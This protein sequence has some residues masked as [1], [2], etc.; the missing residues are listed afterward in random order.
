MASTH[1]KA[2]LLCDIFCVCTT[3]T[4]VHIR[5]LHFASV[6]P[7]LPAARCLAAQLAGHV[8]GLNRRVTVSARESLL[9][10]SSYGL[11]GSPVHPS[12]I[13]LSSRVTDYSAVH[14]A[15]DTA[16]QLSTGHGT[17]ERGTEEDTEE[18]TEK[19]TGQRAL[20]KRRLTQRPLLCAHRGRL[21]GYSS[22]WWLPI[23]PQQDN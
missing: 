12:S 19:G 18:D 17:T 2:R 9:I 7:L 4:I 21:L 13:R 8:Q 3:G 20:D 15:K 16:S 6:A 11:W 22:T 5:L 23:Y 10:F 1:C 14:R